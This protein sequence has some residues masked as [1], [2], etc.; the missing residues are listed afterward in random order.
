MKEVMS[1]LLATSI[2]GLGGLGLYFCKSEEQAGGDDYEE[3]I[4][5]TED[6]SDKN[7]V[8]FLEEDY[9]FKPKKR[10]VK[11]KTKTNRKGLGTKRRY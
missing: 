9:E 7:E 3:E 8:E 1:L 6:K 5:K 10:S 2:L 4:V 11:T